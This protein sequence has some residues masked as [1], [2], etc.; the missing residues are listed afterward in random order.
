LPDSHDSGSDE[1]L[2][3]KALQYV[4]YSSQVMSEYTQCTSTNDWSFPVGRWP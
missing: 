1:V 4:R 2:S 3:P